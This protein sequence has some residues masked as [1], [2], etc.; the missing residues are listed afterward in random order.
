MHWED[1]KE[2][3]EK[4]ERERKEAI[5]DR[6][7]TTLLSKAIFWIT[8]RRFTTMHEVLRLEFVSM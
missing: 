2:K 7:R 8:E 1:Q 6:Q 3:G 4:T 5:I